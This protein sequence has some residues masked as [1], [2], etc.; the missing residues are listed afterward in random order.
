MEGFVAFSA[1]AELF[2]F[3]WCILGASFFAWLMPAVLV[4]TTAL[5]FTQYVTPEKPFEARLPSPELQQCVNYASLVKTGMKCC[6]VG[7]I[8]QGIEIHNWIGESYCFRIPWP[9]AAREEQLIHSCCRV[10][11]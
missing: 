8:S 3:A 11:L 10:G 1:G 9:A 2:L 6:F 7:L 5:T 4:G